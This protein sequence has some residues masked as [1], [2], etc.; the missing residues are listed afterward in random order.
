MISDWRAFFR[1]ENAWFGFIQLAPWTAGAGLMLSLLD[2]TLQVRQWQICARP[3]SRLSSCPTSATQLRLILEISALRLGISIRGRNHRSVAHPQ[4]QA[5]T[6]NSAGQLCPCSGVWKTS[7]ASLSRL[8]DVER[9]VCW[10]DADCNLQVSRWHRQ[11]P[12]FL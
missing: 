12:S 9:H 3:S 7:G 11:R 4:R 5:D 1:N 2:L 10:V 6:R 8:L